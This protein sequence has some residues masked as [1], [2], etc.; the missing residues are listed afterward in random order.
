MTEDLETGTTASLLEVGLPARAVAGPASAPG[1]TSVARP[2]TVEQIAQFALR[3]GDGD[4]TEGARERV[5]QS[6][7]DSV[8]IAIGALGAAPIRDVHRVIGQLGAGRG[9]RLIGGG[10]AAPDRAALFNQSLGRYLDFM[11]NLVTEGEVSHPSDAFGTVFTIA[12]HAGSSGRELMIATGVAYQIAGRIQEEIPILRAGL[13]NT[14][15]A[16][17]G[18]AAAS[19]RLLGLTQARTAHAIALSGV[20]Q[21]ALANIEAEPVG[22][23]K[24]LASGEMGMRSVHDT[25]L[26]RAGVTGPLGVLEGP[27]GLQQLTAATPNFRWPQEKLDIGEQISLKRFEGEVQTQT[28][29]ETTITLRTENKIDAGTIADVLVE[30]P[31]NS[32][33]VLGGGVYGPKDS[34][35]VKEQ[36]DHNLKYGVAVALLDGDVGRAQYAVS[37]IQRADVQT[38]LDKVTVRAAQDLTVRVPGESP[39]RITITLTDGRSFTREQASWL[40]FFRSPMTF[41]QVVAKFNGLTRGRA[42]ARQR[43]DIVSLVR[44]LESHSA[45]DL[46]DILVRIS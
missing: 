30:V 40:G 33:N 31:L 26:A 11:D 2:T 9:A 27:F 12:D 29:I 36:A 3:A 5:R 20:N 25:F 15:Q 37:R 41:E 42:S 44:R 46:M 17:F 14:T 8:G 19:S 10:R 32:F 22:N 16:A 13:R 6:I 43:R 38:L 23:Y 34:P 45:R 28:P 1:D 39:A 18:V 35:V 21:L 7:L 4:F 24:G